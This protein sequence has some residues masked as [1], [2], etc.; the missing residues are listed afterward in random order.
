MTIQSSTFKVQKFLS[1]QNPNQQ[2]LVHIHQGD[3]FF[4]TK[5]YKQAAKAYGKTQQPFEEIALKFLSVNDSEALKNYVEH[6]LEAF[7]K[8]K[9]KVTLSV[10]VQ[11]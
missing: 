2:N 1:G 6:K 9:N 3:H 5:L 4:E 10:C 7:T 11:Y 8:L